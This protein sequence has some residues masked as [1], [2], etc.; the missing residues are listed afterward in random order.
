MSVILNKQQASTLRRLVKEIED[1]EVQRQALSDEKGE[2]FDEARA[3]KLDVKTIR[4]MLGRRQRECDIVH[5]EDER[6]A[7][8]ERALRGVEGRTGTD[9]ATRA[10]A[11]D[12]AEEEAA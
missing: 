7:A 9:R 5:E 1:I 10:R 3:L 12:E 2:K 6:L 11:R 4:R 8:Y